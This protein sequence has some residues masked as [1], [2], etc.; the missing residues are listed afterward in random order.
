MTNSE[1]TLRLCY[2][3]YTYLNGFDLASSFFTPKKK[4]TILICRI[5]RCDKKMIK[6]DFAQLARADKYSGVLIKN[7]HCAK[8]LYDKFDF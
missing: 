5:K 8:K 7:H 6:I 2:R 3:Q 4:L 1:V